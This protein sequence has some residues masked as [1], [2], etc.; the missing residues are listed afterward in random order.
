MATTNYK[1][2]TDETT[3]E[4]EMMYSASTNLVACSGEILNY[5]FVTPAIVSVGSIATWESLSK[6]IYYKIDAFNHMKTKFYDEP[7]PI[8][9]INDVWYWLPMSQWKYQKIFAPTCFI[10]P[11]EKTL[12]R[13]GKFVWSADWFGSLQAMCMKNVRKLQEDFEKYKSDYC[14][15]DTRSYMNGMWN[16]N[17]YSYANPKDPRSH[18]S[19]TKDIFR[20][21]IINTKLEYMF[22][23]I[24]EFYEAFVYAIKHI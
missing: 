8:V 24:S 11:F 22:L 15:G 2:L 4:D 5:E 21:F 17:N 1:T 9:L 14:N 16:A 20:D 10:L 19:S 3:R 12:N 18:T 6:N 23:D 7:V 13:N